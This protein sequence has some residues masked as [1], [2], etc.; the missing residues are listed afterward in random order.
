MCPEEEGGRSP[1]DKLD[2]F[3][4]VDAAVVVDVDV[5]EVPPPSPPAVGSPLLS[6]PPSSNQLL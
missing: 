2:R 4:T 6:G 5:D 3:V 1:L